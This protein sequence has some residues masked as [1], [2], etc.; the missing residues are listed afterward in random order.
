MKFNIHITCFII[1]CAVVSF[2]SCRKDNETIATATACCDVLPNAEYL[3]GGFTTVFQNGNDAFMFPLFN[4]DSEHHIQFDVGSVLFNS[5]FVEIGGSVNDG[6]GPLFNMTSCIGCHSNNGRSQPPMSEDDF[7]SGLLIRL[8]IAGVNEHE[9]P[10]SAPGFGT[11]LQTRAIN[12]QQPEGKFFIDQEPLIITYADGT[13][14]TLFQPYIQFYNLY[15]D[16]PINILKSARN[17]SPVFGL[18]LLEAVSETS[19]LTQVDEQDADGNYISGKA[20]YVWN[21]ASQSM[22]I[23]RFGWKAS[24]P[25]IV[26]QC[27]EAFQQDMGITSSSFFAAENC[28]GQTNCNEGI[29]I[30][31]DLTASIVESIANFIKGLAVPAPRNLEDAQV[32]QGRQL[33]Y[34]IGCSNCHTPQLQ[35][36]T[37]TWPELSNQIIFPYTDLLLHDLGEGL[38]DGRP[39]F[40]ASANEWRT[41]PLW[42]IGL[43]KIVNPNATFLHD[44]RAN[45]L[46][47]AILWHSGEAYWTRNS[48][49]ALN[50]SEREAIIKFLEAL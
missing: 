27:A 36:G 13:S 17:T 9:G 8:S 15:Q 50:V 4:I 41:P 37:S 18:G 25:S 47:Q 3:A 28:V 19:I 38:A 31:T 14:I 7:F 16:M 26:Q 29:G 32:Q 22:S 43:T 46:E 39:D 6:L 44:G 20:N 49:V 34:D 12:L 11:Q 21:V 35:T 48:F 5:E 23:G 30:E 45:T 24:S 1:V 42:G 33:F 2:S 40:S 10:L